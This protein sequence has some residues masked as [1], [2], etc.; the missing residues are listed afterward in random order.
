MFMVNQFKTY[1]VALPSRDPNQLWLVMASLRLPLSIHFRLHQSIRRVL[2][3]PLPFLVIP[4]RN[5]LEGNSII[6]IRLKRHCISI[7]LS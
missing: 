6:Y 2:D 4:G 5:R 7:E 3:T 1:A